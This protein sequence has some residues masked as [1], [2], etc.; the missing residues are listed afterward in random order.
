VIL[1]QTTQMGRQPLPDEHRLVLYGRSISL[2]YPVDGDVVTNGNESDW[3]VIGDNR[4]P[5]IK[6]HHTKP[7]LDSVNFMTT[8][9][10][11]NGCRW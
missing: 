7:L 2:K 3:P 8:I 1:F 9:F 10:L 11:T 5:I 4:V 6:T